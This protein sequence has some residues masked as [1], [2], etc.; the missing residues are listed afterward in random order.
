MGFFRSLFAVIGATAAAFLLGMAF[1]YFRMALGLE[2][3]GLMMVFPAVAGAGGFI[4]AIIALLA[5]GG[6]R[7]SASESGG[8]SGQA[9]AA[10]GRRSKEEVPG[11]PTFDFDKAQQ[12]VKAKDKAE[13]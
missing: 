9:S 8:R 5:V 4:A 7:P 10:Q 3:E 13:E 6:S 11:M 12:A 2:T 1:D